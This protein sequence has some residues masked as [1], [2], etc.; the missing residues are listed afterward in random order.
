MKTPIHDSVPDLKRILGSM[1][2]GAGHPMSVKE[3]RKCLMEVAGLRGGGTDVFANVKESDIRMA[4]DELKTDLEK[5]QAGFVLAEIAGFFRFQS[6]PACG[7][8]LKHLLNVDKPSRLSRPALETLAI[9]AYRQPVARSDIESVRGVNVDHVVK[10]LMEMQLV[11][12]VGRSDLPGRPFLYGTTQVFFEHFG[13]QN[14]E[15]LNNMEPMLGVV[16][17]QNRDARSSS[18]RQMTMDESM[19]GK[20][21]E[22]L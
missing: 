11:R 1:I 18:D 14:L 16:Q 10:S 21:S 9:I 15:E 17:T 7:R 3:I 4:L 2:F 13:L 8:W 20:I 5:Q 19:E 6:D 22:S 12:I